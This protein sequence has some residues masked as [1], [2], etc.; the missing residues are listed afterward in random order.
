MVKIG[1]RQFLFKSGRALAGTALASLAATSVRSQR[2][3]GAN[4]RVNLALIG[5]GGRGRMVLRGMVDIGANAAYVCDLHPG[6]LEK[7]VELITKIQP[8]PPKKVK[9]MRE[10]LDAGDVDAVIVATPDHWHAL[11]AIRA[12]QAGKDVYVEKPHSHSIWESHRIIEAARKY[13]RI[14]Q[15]GTQNRSAPYN[16][17]GRDYV[18]SGK[19]GGIYLVK[20]YNLKSG[21]AFHLGHSGPCPAGFDWNTWLGPAPERPFHQNI[22]SAGWHK[23]WDFSGGDL[24]DDGIHQVDLAMMMMGD[25]GLPR[26][27]SCSGGRLQ[28]KG[29]DAEVPDVQ[30][31]TYEFSDFIMTFELTNYPR[32]MQKTTATI[33]QKDLFPYWTQNATRIELYGSELMMMVGRHGGGWQVMAPYGK[34]ADQMYGRFPDEPH[35]KNFLECVKDRKRPNADIEVIHPAC[36]MVHMGNIAYRLGNK[37]L[38]FDAKTQRFI[39]NDQANRLLKREYRRNYEVPEQV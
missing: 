23:F 25:P 18:K 38:W 1:R 7:A 4:E 6:A 22:F 24:A 27:V 21:T 11:A 34:V 39:D 16:I 9:D 17:A 32:Y 10:V 8:Q 35:E 2:V 19:L 20:V 3:L 14:V 28:Y 33:R 5:C 30:I 26:A 13:N 36:T 31:V 15:V 37:K 12:C 29:D